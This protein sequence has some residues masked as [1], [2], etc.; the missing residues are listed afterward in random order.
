[1]ED[2]FKHKSKKWDMNNKRVQNAKGV[3]EIILNNID[4]THTHTL[5]DVG[6]GTGLLSYFISQKPK[7]ITALDSSAS[8]L[9][10]LEAKIDQF[11]CPISIVNTALDDF[12]CNGCFDGIISSM[13]IHHIENIHALFEKFFTLLKDEGFIAIAD[14]GSEDGTFHD[15]NEGVHHFGFD[16]ER[17]KKMAQDAGFKECVVQK[18]HT[19][20][21][22]HRHFDVFVLLAKK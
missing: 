13:T 4:I 19:I 20:E 16:F 18:A 22:P 9:A 6:A 10:E 12:N 2:K 14:L 3:A 8:M 7:K 17:L 5:L 21:K 11:A 15:D 1:M